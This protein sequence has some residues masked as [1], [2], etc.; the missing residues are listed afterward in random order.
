MMTT[1]D[2]TT[3]NTTVQ[4]TFTETATVPK[5]FTT[6]LLKYTRPIEINETTAQFPLSDDSSVMNT[7][8][9]F[10]ATTPTFQATM[11]TFQATIPKFQA[12]MTPNT[13]GEPDG[14]TA[15][16]T[17][18]LVTS[19]PTP[20]LSTQKRLEYSY[21]TKKIGRSGK[22]NP[23]IVVTQASQTTES[24][25]GGKHNAAKGYIWSIVGAGI[26]V[27]LVIVFVLICCCR[28]IQKS[29]RFE[30]YDNHTV[31]MTRIAGE[32]VKQTEADMV[33]EK[34]T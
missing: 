12:T 24:S 4:V 1:T 31:H 22:I 21:T 11:P 23:T 25:D 30:Y 8:A 16:T 7:T 18:V 13:Y 14:T 26:G 6:P 29:K 3:E 28:R 2:Q 17:L 19:T 32:D 27:L 33:Y 5:N 15:E 10:Q 20:E 9:T 34:L